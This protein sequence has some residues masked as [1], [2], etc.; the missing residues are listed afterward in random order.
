M[1]AT[2]L[3]PPLLAHWA[4][5]IGLD[6]A[7]KL[8]DAFGGTRLYIPEPDHLHP[9]HPIAQAIGLDAARALAEDYRGDSLT[10][11]QA[12]GYLAALRRQR[13]L[14]DLQAGL[15]V[16]QAALKHGVHER[17]IYRIAARARQETVQPDLFADPTGS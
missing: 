7:L 10:V 16:R 12:A 1:T 14:D 6:A 11:P 8:A 2:D 17:H 5:R 15:S 4:E 13:I 3:L 9:A